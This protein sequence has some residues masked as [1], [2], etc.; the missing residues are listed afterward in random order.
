MTQDEIA[1]VRDAKRKQVSSLSVLCS[2]FETVV[3]FG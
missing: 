3:P 1:N 2:A